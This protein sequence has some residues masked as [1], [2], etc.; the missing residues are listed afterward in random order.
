MFIKAITK[1]WNLSHQS[2]PY[3][4]NLN[5]ISDMKDSEVTKQPKLPDTSICVADH[6]DEL[7]KDSVIDY[8]R[9]TDKESVPISYDRARAEA[10]RKCKHAPW[11]GTENLP[12]RIPYK[13]TS[14]LFHKYKVI[15]KCMVH[16]LKKNVPSSSELRK[17]LSLAFGK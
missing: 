10:V 15:R 9:K 4:S 13:K 6:N 2:H 17:C 8:V 5:N 11:H 12:L 3:E 14:S 7:S 1:F 16:Y